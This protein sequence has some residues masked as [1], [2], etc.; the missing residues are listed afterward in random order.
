MQYMHARLAHSGMRI[1]PIG[2]TSL[3]GQTHLLAEVGLACETTVAPLRAQ[4]ACMPTGACT[5]RHTLALHGVL[6]HA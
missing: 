6:S 4:R 5:T 1:C 2:C 3:A